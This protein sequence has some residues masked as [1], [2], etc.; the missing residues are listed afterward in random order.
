MERSAGPRTNRIGCGTI[1]RSMSRRAVLLALAAGVAV[2]G[3]GG[4]SGGAGRP[5]TGSGAAAGAGAAAATDSSR[6]A[7][8][9]ESVAVARNLW[10]KAEVVRRLEEAG[11]VVT[12]SGKKA[13][14]PAL[15]VEGDRLLVS[16]GELAIYVYPDA[17]ARERDAAGLDTT[18]HGLPSIEKPRYIISGNLI[19]IL[20]TPHDRLAER[21]ALVL[22]A[23]HGGG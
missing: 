20:H 6:A 11:L 17:G 12:D 22:T 23:R 9:A 16:G 15:H 19:A 8:A 10:N 3:C 14:E 4:D 2:A 13:R 1:D 21:V 18:L 7:A 5:G